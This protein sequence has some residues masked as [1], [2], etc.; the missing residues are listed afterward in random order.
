MVGRV[1]YQF[2][3]PVGACRDVNELEFLACIHQTTSTESRVDASIVADDVQRLLISRH[4]L[5]VS[6][7]DIEQHVLV[8]LVGRPDRFPDAVMDL[9]QMMALLL[10]PQLVRSGE[11]Q[12]NLDAGEHERL[13][14]AGSAE[15]GLSSSLFE[16]V[17]RIILEDS[18][19]DTGEEEYPVL[20]MGVL[21]KIFST[22]GENNVD[23]VVLEKMIER[24][25]TTRSGGPV[26]L[27]PETFQQALT[28]DVKLYRSEW[29]DRLSTHFEDVQTAQIERHRR[30]ALASF[31]SI[32]KL[33]FSKV[34]QAGEANELKR[35]F[36]FP[37]ID[38]DA[39]TFESQSFHVLLIVSVVCFYVGYYNIILPSTLIGCRGSTFACTTL[40]MFLDWLAILAQLS[41]SGT[42]FVLLASLSNHSYH[43][44]TWS[45]FFKLMGTA[46]VIP[47]LATVTVIGFQD[48]VETKESNSVK[49]AQFAAFFTAI[50][51]VSMQ[52]GQLLSILMPEFDMKKLKSQYLARWLFSSGFHERDTKK[53]A[54][55]KVNRMVKN[56]LRLHEGEDN[57]GFDEDMEG[58]VNRTPYDLA[59]DRFVDL[60]TEKEISGGFIWVW[61]HFFTSRLSQQEGALTVCF[62]LTRVI[63]L[64]PAIQ[65]CEVI[66]F[67]CSFPNS[68]PFR[69]QVC[70]LVHGSS[71]AMLRSGWCWLRSYLLLLLA[72][73]Q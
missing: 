4:G 26:M 60:L 69:Q 72:Y 10:I 55:F 2:N 14:H 73:Q 36:T 11:E 52:C 71:A 58:L 3:Q 9:R 16:T 47:T 59:M 20:T 48:V 68:L 40:N 49:W 13:M 18:G 27:N 19:V 45:T 15:R 25:D 35:V 62:V 24:A 6:K 42:A 63:G 37:T 67:Y 22:Y 21:R 64:E 65:N 1:P 57:V 5:Q 70:F 33:S 54:V 61:K 23:D 7:R 34:T 46:V 66:Y 44:K 50:T 8:D 32:A 56:A 30:A 17:L 39:D 53:A 43:R 28:S 38:M 31:A 41:L 29:E 51:L 12:D